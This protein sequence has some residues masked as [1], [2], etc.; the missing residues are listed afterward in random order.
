MP[1]SFIS[2]FAVALTIITR[3]VGVCQCQGIRQPAEPLPKRTD[4]PLDGSPLSTAVV[5]QEG[6]PGIPVKVFSDILTIRHVIGADGNGAG[7]DSNGELDGHPFRD[8]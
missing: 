3:S 4:A 5:M 8:S 6:K 7:E 1:L 2:T